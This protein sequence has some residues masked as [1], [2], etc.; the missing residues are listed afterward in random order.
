MRIVC[1]T[2]VFLL[3][4]A[5]LPTWFSC[6]AFAQNASALRGIVTDP[7]GARIPHATIQLKSPN[8]EQTQTTDANGQYAFTAIAP[9]HYEVEVTAEAFKADHRPDFNINGSMTLN[10]QLALEGQ[11]QVVTVQD[12][13]ETAVST[14]PDANASATVL[15]KNELEALSDDPDELA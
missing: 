14:D 5:I 6:A 2:V 4:V 8:G 11:S 7:S 1:K 3:S 12:D 10:V 13:A 15:G 9:G